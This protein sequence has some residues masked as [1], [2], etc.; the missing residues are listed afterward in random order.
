MN[1]AQKLALGRFER[2]WVVD[3]NFQNEPIIYT[4][5][6]GSPEIVEYVIDNLGKATLTATYPYTIK[7]KTE[8]N[9]YK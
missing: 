6:K 7:L 3:H 4:H 9:Q 8:L 1:E 5:K 2:H